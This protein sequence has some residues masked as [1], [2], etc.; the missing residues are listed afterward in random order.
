ML[1]IETSPTHTAI[2]GRS[3]KYWFAQPYPSFF[4]YVEGMKQPYPWAARAER[5][6]TALF[7]GSV[8]TKN[9]TSN[10]L[11]RLLFQQCS[12]SPSCVWE[13]TAHACSGVV[14]QTSAIYKFRRARYCLA[15]PGDSLTRKSLFDSLLA[16]CVPVIFVRGS[17][18]QYD[19]HLS[20]QE[21]AAVSVYISMQRMVRERASFMEV[22]EAIPAAELLAKQREIER[23]A[24]R[25][26]YAVVRPSIVLHP[27]PACI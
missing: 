16:G 8:K 22:L 11:R 14:N 12:N 24:P 23:I 18:L 10:V 27:T 6:L 19:W 17:L 21:V 2:P 26:Q 3:K 9:P 1:T 4:H 7:I 20:E 5:D 25:L 13:K 15:P